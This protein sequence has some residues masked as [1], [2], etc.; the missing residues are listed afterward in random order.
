MYFKITILA[1][2]L[3]AFSIPSKAEYYPGDDITIDEGTRNQFDL[4]LPDSRV[5]EV[6]LTGLQKD[7][8]IRDVKMTYNYE[9]VDKT[10]KLDRDFN[11]SKGQERKGEV[12]FDTE[13][14]WRGDRLFIVLTNP[15][16]TVFH[17]NVPYREDAESKLVELFLSNPKLN[18]QM[19][20][21]IRTGT[22]LGQ[23]YYKWTEHY[24]LNKRGLTKGTHLYVDSRRLATKLK[25][26][27]HINN[28]WSTKD[29]H[30][31]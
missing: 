15:S 7:H 13:L 12:R 4:D 3:T 16:T 2:F 18:I 14:E 10:A 26:K 31:P 29:G 27:I 23:Q 21:R 30:T 9:F 22:R 24:D 17:F 8:Q 1:F 5:W 19:R 6:E 11:F 20:K 28:S 25:Y